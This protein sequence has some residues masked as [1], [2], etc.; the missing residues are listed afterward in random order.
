MEVPK[1]VIENAE[2]GLLPAADRGGV[3]LGV[4]ASSTT[5][6]GLVGGYTMTMPRAETAV[7]S[8]FKL[9]SGRP[10]LTSSFVGA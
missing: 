10:K 4:V 2:T 3:L 7:H 5:A 1:L 6:R 9:P 8:P